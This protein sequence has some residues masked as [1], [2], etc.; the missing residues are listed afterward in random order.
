MVT[1][2]S[3]VAMVSTLKLQTIISSHSCIQQATSNNIPGIQHMNKIRHLY[4]WHFNTTFE[5]KVTHKVS[6][7]VNIN[8]DTCYS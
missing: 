5:H 3:T 8:V 7:C 6:K 1:G 4:R 2:N